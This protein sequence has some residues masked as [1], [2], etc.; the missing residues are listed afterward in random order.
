M[1]IFPRCLPT[2]KWSAT[3]WSNGTGESCKKPEYF[4][5]FRY[6][7]F[8]CTHIPNVISQ[9]DS[10]N[11][12]L[13]RNSPR[14]MPLKKSIFSNFFDTGV[15]M[16]LTVLYWFQSKSCPY[17]W[18]STLVAGF[19]RNFKTKVDLYFSREFR[20]CFPNSNW[21]NCSLLKKGILIERLQNIESS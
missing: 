8:R 17:I 5:N 12:I 7:L 14:W 19:H 9:N 18:A 11:S 21:S 16:A 10:W 4:M 15:L 20:N 1:H 6:C 2:K 3:L 13:I